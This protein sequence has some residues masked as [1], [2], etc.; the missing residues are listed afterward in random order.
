MICLHGVGTP[1]CRSRKSFLLS[2]VC[3]PH[4]AARAD[5]KEAVLEQVPLP[6]ATAQKDTFVF[7]FLGLFN[8]APPQ[9]ESEW[10][11]RRNWLNQITGL[12]VALWWS[13]AYA[14]ADLCPPQHT[15]RADR[16]SQAVL[17]GMAWEGLHPCRLLMWSSVSLL[18]I[19]RWTTS[20]FVDAGNRVTA[21][22]CRYQC[23]SLL[24]PPQSDGD[25]W[26]DEPDD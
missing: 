18:S 6:L 10:P 11:E 25:S 7:S 12:R 3:L 21:D 26:Q 8:L 14:Q 5:A 23:C 4:L 19:S 15:Y 9:W 20:R 17:S 24:G 22:C 16:Q 13:G 2:C 1:R